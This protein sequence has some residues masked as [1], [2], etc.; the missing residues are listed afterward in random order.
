MSKYEILVR[1][2]RSVCPLCSGLITRMGFSIDGSKGMKEIAVNAP[3]VFSSHL[4]FRCIDCGAIFTAECEGNYEGILVVNSR[5]IENNVEKHNDV[6][7]LGECNF[8]N[9]GGFF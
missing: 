5:F 8:Y 4:E 7:I 3:P 1:D 9:K 2:G 6:P